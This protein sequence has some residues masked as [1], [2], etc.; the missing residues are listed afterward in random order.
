MKISRKQNNHGKTQKE[1]LSQ[2]KSARTAVFV[3]FASLLLLA[4]AASVQ[5]ATTFTTTT[6]A[7]G[8]WG[9]ATNWA[10]GVAPTGSQAGNIAANGAATIAL[11]L[12]TATTIGCINDTHGSAENFTI[13]ASGTVAMTMDNTGGANN[14]LGNAD[15]FIGETSSGGITFLLNIVIQNTDLDLGNT[16]S[17]TPTLT[18]GTLGTSTITAATARNLKIYQN[19]ATSTKSININSSIGSSGSVITVQNVGTG[20]G[21]ST[22]NLNGVVGPNAAVIQNST[23]SS[24]SLNAANTYTGATTISMGKLIL[25]ASGSLA[26]ASNVSIAAGGTLDM[27]AQTTYTLG[28][29]AT[30]SAS[31]TATAATIKGGTTVSLGSRPVSLTYDGSHAPLTLSAG[32]LQLSSN[33]FTIV[34]PGTALGVGTYTLVSTPGAITGTPNS[35]P[36][37][38]G[39]NGVASGDTGT[40]SVSGNNVVLTVTSGGGSNVTLTNNDAT[41]TSSFS[42]AGNW[43]NA[44]APSSANTYQSAF[45][46]RVAATATFQ[47]SSLEILSGGDLRVKLS[48]STVTINN[49]ILDS[50]GILDMGITGTA[51]ISG[52]ISLPSGQ[53]YITGGSSGGGTL[54]INSAISGAGGFIDSYSLS[55]GPGADIL[56]ASNSY[57]GPTTIPNNTPDSIVLQLGNANAVKNSTVTVSLTNGLQ[58]STG[59]SA[60]NIGGLAGSVPIALTNVSG[61]AVTA[62][63]GGNNASTTYSGVIGGSGA[64]TKAGTGTLT[65]SAANTYTGT[66]TISAGTL[67]LGASGSL[68]S[69]SSISIAAG[70]TFDVSAQTTYTLGSSATLSASGTASAATING[71]TTVNLGSR[72]V[73]VTYDGSHT[74]LTLS[75]GTLELSGNIFTVDVPGSALG[76]GTYTLVATTRV[77]TG[78]PD[79]VPSYAGNGIVIGDTGTVSVSGDN[80]ILTVTGGSSSVSAANSTVSPPLASLTANGGSTQVITVQARGTNNNN[81]TTGGATVVFTLS[82]TGTI[83]GTTD[84]DNGTYTATLTAPTAVNSAS[85]TA[86]LNGVAVGTAVG[87]TNCEATYYSTNFGT[88]LP[89]LTSQLSTNFLVGAGTFA[90]VE[91][92]ASG[93]GPIYNN[94]SCANCHNFPN[95]GGSGT[96]TVTRFGENTNGVFNGLVNQGGTLLQDNSTTTNFEVIPSNAN[97]TAKRITIALWGN[98]L[99]EAIPASEISSN[100]AVTNVDGIQG[101]VAMVT[102][103][104]SGQQTVGRFGWKGQLGTLISFVAD[105]ENNEMGITSRIEPTG[106][107]PNSNTNLYNQI[108]T[109]ADPNDVVDSS[110][111]ANVDR[112]ADYVRLF[113]PPPTLPLTASAQAGQTLFAQISCTECHTPTMYTTNAFVPVEN[114]TNETGVITALSSKAVNLYSDLA[115]HNMGSLADGIAQGAASTNQMLTAPLWG[116]RENNPYMHDG[117]ALTVDAAIRDH[118][119]DAAAAAARYTN[120]S[121]NQQQEVVNFLNS[122]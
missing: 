56:T 80:V 17:T 78:T 104:V 38:T 25:G 119:G 10:G 70:A 99:I 26:A 11:T 117:R 12:N 69:S 68:A 88:P 16:G 34:V 100:A 31:G 93:L 107:A 94:S 9:T 89:G 110:G 39:G 4:G 52:N 115:L 87:A 36:S 8:N 91:S 59:I 112:R 113:S 103:L 64:L 79:S 114:L 81:I 92:I 28:A 42:S 2:K 43:S 67:L 116:L 29:S 105:A 71:G 95:T 57:S 20:G 74:P 84:N 53:A 15:A 5:A 101:T 37:F 61:T 30:L 51:A 49:F 108:N 76:V 40:L 13:N 63:V 19:Q 35:T 85:I 72:P 106:Q 111:K 21:V 98:G 102:D 121:T 86:T 90:Q 1:N 50:G 109:V 122:L 14:L 118:A 62:S 7:N 77:I 60:F 73:T 46:L 22:M 47:G 96:A 55:S 83:S 41:G 33:P 75:A 48:G 58:Y 66:T 65:L 45:T 82:G 32:A 27:S 44:Q 97:V 18:I 120:L 6:T 23:N 24:L 54:T 3:L